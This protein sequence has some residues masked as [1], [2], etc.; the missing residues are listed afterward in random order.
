MK[1]T[2]FAV[3]SS[4]FTVEIAR[5]V[6]GDFIY[7]LPVSSFKVELNTSKTTHDV[8]THNWLVE[9]ETTD[10]DFIRKWMQGAHDELLPKTPQQ[11]IN[12]YRPN[13]GNKRADPHV[14]LYKATISLSVLGKKSTIYG[15]LPVECEL[16]EPIKLENAQR[17][18]RVT[19]KLRADSFKWTD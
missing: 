6:T 7:L 5:P 3:R 13:F 8:F 19:V 16:S 18:L 14:S 17:P 10:V 11:C 1:T 2:I 4:D 9:L 15:V 12:D